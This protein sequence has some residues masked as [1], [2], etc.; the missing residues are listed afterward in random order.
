M[1]HRV[2]TFPLP[3]HL[4]EV[5]EREVLGGRNPDGF[6]GILTARQTQEGRTFSSYSI[7]SPFNC[8]FLAAVP[9]EIQLL[10]CCNVFVEACAAVWGALAKAPPSFRDST[11]AA[12]SYD[13]PQRRARVRKGFHAF[14]SF[15]ITSCFLGPRRHLVSRFCRR[16]LS[17]GNMLAHFQEVTERAKEAKR[18]MDS[19]STHQPA[20]SHA[21]LPVAVS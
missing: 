3:A 20:L 19:L 4:A 2:L 15:T 5:P 14:M 18:V 16:S 6:P 9:R 11:L 8:D 12:P 13:G 10:L 21:R 17:A 7:L 1:H